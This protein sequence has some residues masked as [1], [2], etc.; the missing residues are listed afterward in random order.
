MVLEKTFES[1][2]DCKEIKWVNP[3][4]NQ[5]Q[6]FIGM[7][8]DEVPTLWSYDAKSQLIGRLWYWARLKAKEEGDGGE[9]DG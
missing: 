8:E 5:P 2:L 6:I 1:S 9:W 7:T 4:G 3:K